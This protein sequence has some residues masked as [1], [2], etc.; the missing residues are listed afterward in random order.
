MHKSLAVALFGLLAVL[1]SGCFFNVTS[2]T[3]TDG[4]TVYVGEVQNDGPP[5]SNPIVTGTFYDAAGNVI[6]TQTGSACRVMPTKSVAA[7]KVTLPPGTAKPARAEWALSGR[8][9]AD[10]Y[11]ADGLSGQLFGT[12]P[13]TPGTAKPQVFGEIRNDSANTYTGGYVCVAWVNAQGE[14]LRV[15]EATAAGGEF[16]PGDVLPFS[17]RESVPAEA[18]DALFFLDAGVTP[19]GEVRPTFADVPFSAYQNEF[20]LNGPNFAGQGTLYVSLGEIHNSGPKSFYPR[21][22]AVL[23]DGAGHPTGVGE[24]SRDLC[25][26]PAFPGSFAYGG[27]IMATSTMPPPPVERRI[28]AQRFAT[29]EAVAKLT[30]SNLAHSP[31]SAAIELVSGKLKNPGTGR[32][33]AAVVCAG[34]YNA[35]GLL[36]GVGMA[37]LPEGIAAGATVSFAVSV[38]VFG[39]VASIK[40]IAGGRVE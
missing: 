11:L 36:V 18:T 16:A 35:D 31:V 22:I 38:P 34:A 4:T 27:Y 13:A 37:E 14:V 10:A 5:L 29:I 33:A 20:E 12:G 39:D 17:L 40:A 25:D 19:P 2:Y 21:M 23:R 30:P 7:F 15:A 24:S 8:E 26:V 1:S 3:E 6:T 32:L 9:V 28:E